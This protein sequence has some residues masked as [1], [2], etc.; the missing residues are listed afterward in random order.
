[1][2]THALTRSMSFRKLQISAFADHSDTDQRVPQISDSE[3]TKQIL[4][5]HKDVLAHSIVL[6]RTKGQPT[7]IH[8]AERSM[9]S[10]HAVRTRRKYKLAKSACNQCQKRKTKCSDERPV[11][12]FC[13][14]RDLECSWNTVNGLTRTADL[15]KKVY[16]AAGRSDDLGTFLDTMR[17]STDQV[18]SMLLVKL[19]CGMSLKDLLLAIH[20]TSSAMDTSGLDLLEKAANARLFPISLVGSGRGMQPTE[21]KPQPLRESNQ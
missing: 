10:G 18:S 7:T 8:G 21:V 13:S 5:D 9:S 14:D 17:H 20:S 2:L 16:E 4:A 19:R 3:A 15:K 11:C 12:R 1:M 6:S